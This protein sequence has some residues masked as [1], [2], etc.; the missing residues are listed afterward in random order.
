MIRGAT[1]DFAAQIGRGALGDDAAAVDD[2]HAVTRHLDLGQN[3]RGND[4]RHA[5]AQAGDEVA[6]DQNLMRIEADRRLVHD[7]HGRLGEDGF[8]DADALA[9]TFGKLADDFV[10]DAFQV[11][12]FEDFV[13][14]RAE[15]AAGDFFQAAAE[16]EVLADAHVFRQ[17]VIFRHVA[18]EAF[19]GVGLGGDGV[20]ADADRARVGRQVAGEDAHRGGLAGAVGPEEPDD[21]AAGDGEAQIGDRSHTRVSFYEVVDFDGGCRRRGHDG[22]RR[23]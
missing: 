10:A 20:A 11:A 23:A 4:H 12:E 3:V 13:D 22:E 7:D 16:I 8:G 1:E 6:H 14:A 15:F 19:D 18:D 5:T 2:E 17:W 21:L 9:V